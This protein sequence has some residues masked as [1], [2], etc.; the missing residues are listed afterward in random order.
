MNTITG[1]EVSQDLKSR[2]ST[3]SMGMIK[4]NNLVSS[5]EKNK[6]SEK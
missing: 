6:F 1:Q 3:F 4:A 2:S 5:N